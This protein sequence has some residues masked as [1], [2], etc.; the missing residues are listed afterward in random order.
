MGPDNLKIETTNVRGCI[1]PIAFCSKL[2][3][4]FCFWREPERGPTTPQQ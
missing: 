3:N 4:L 1:K 2:N